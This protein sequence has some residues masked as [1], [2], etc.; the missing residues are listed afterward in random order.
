MIRSALIAEENY[1]NKVGLISENPNPESEPE[2]NAEM[3]F[4]E[5]VEY[6]LNEEKVELTKE[7]LMEIYDTEVEYLMF[8][9]VV[10]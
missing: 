3:D 7:E 10:E 8:I 6:A 4:N 5:M 1:M 9:G 2:S